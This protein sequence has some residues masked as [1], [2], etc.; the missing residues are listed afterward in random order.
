MVR[1]DHTLESRRGSTCGH[2]TCAQRIITLHNPAWHPGTPWATSKLFYRHICGRCCQ[3]RRTSD[4]DHNVLGALRP[5]EVRATCS[6][7]GGRQAGQQSLV[8]ATASKGSS[9]HCGRTSMPPTADQTKCC[10]DGSKR[11][12]SRAEAVKCALGGNLTIAIGMARSWPVCL[13]RPPVQSRAEHAQTVMVRA[14][15]LILPCVSSQARAHY[16]ILGVA[17]AARH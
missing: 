17:A 1:S 10:R 5:C 11:G 9:T 15:S 6:G 13:V 2:W 14:C 12:W 7:D 16:N 3:R 8:A 4:P